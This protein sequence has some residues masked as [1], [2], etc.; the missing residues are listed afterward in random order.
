MDQYSLNLNGS[1]LPDEISLETDRSLSCC[2][3]TKDD[4]LCIINKLD[5]NKAQSLKKT[6][7][8]ML[9]TCSDS[10]GRAL[11]LICKASLY[12]GRFSVETKR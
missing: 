1:V 3:F 9:K 2:H 8:C 12:R 6:S 7:I 10:I 11:N 4:I 5:P